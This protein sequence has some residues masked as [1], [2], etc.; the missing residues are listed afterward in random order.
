[1]SMI[2]K[3]RE[4][5][6]SIL[7]KN[8][9]GY[10]SPIDYNLFAKQAQ[11]DLFEDY[12]YV[13]NKQIN[14]ENMRLS[15]TGHADIARQ[16]N[17]VIDTF[18]QYKVL[19]PAVLNPGAPAVSQQTFDL[20]DDWYTFVEVIWGTSCEEGTSFSNKECER[21]S[22]YEIRR[23]N[24]S[25][26]TAPSPQFPAYIFSQQGYPSLEGSGTG[27]YGNLSNQ[28]TLYPPPENT[29]TLVC[30]L[31]YVRYPKDPVWTYSELLDAAGRPTGEAFFNSSIS[32]Y[33]DF[34]LP[35]SDF[36]DLVNK[37]L[38]YAGMSI[39]EG[40][41]VAFAQQ[42]QLEQDREEDPM[43]ATKKRTK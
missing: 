38:Q 34:E 43:P 40:S 13:Y 39:R 7:N 32:G 5:V 19:T 15:G 31:T 23:L 35:T 17:E 11:L 20:P 36:G 22:E 18:T 4:T 1:M 26:L 28:I 16:L 30:A 3:V 41:V 12:F 27:N 33:Q 10:L 2:N 25:N 9:Y 42:E 21:V 8:N 14:A 6:L 24:R 37:I 29:C